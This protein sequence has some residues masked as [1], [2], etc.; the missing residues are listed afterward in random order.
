MDKD[1]LD[2]KLRLIRDALEKNAKPA[3]GKPTNTLGQRVITKWRYRK[4]PHNGSSMLPE[5]CKNRVQLF[6]DLV[7]QSSNEFSGF[8]LHDLQALLEKIRLI[9]NYTRLLLVEWDARWVNPLTLASKGWKPYQ[10]QSQSQAVFK[11]CC[12]HAIM[13]IQSSKN[14]DDVTGHNK[15]LNEKIWNSNIIGNHLRECPWRKNQFDLN[16]GYYLNSQN[17][18]MD[19]ERIH[20]SIDKISS[21]SKEFY[22]KRN[23]SRIFHYLT[24]REMQKLAHFFNCKD[25]S[26]VGLLLLGYMKF[27]E[28][29]LVQ[30]TACFHR[31]SIKGLEHTDF[32]GHAL[33]CRFYNKEFLPKM[34]LELIPGENNALTRIGVGERLDK[35]E[36][37]LQNL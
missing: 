22:I 7:Q 11:C 3:S 17:L 20:T 4:K 30:C 37:V 23:S 10:G 15:K 29:N 32:N 14:G 21:G 19:I 33:W 1:A 8:R 35:L 25:Y 6:D 27:Q 12:C 5:K 16:K 13:T 26:L 36:T 2:L 31:A 18:I 34:L 9:Q 28:D 24:E